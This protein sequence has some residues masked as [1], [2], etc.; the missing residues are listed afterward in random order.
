MKTVQLENGKDHADKMDMVT[1]VKTASVSTNPFDL[2]KLKLSQ[3]FGSSGGGV[4]KKL[5]MV[6]VRKPNKQTFFRVIPGDDFRIMTAILEIKD[7]GSDIYLI[8]P[9]LH[10]ELVEDMNVVQIVT[11]IDRQNNVVLW[12][13]KMPRADGRSNSWNESAMAAA[14]HAEKQWIRLVPNMSIG[15][16]DV[17]V[18]KKDFPDPEMPEVSF[19]KLIE[20]AFK[21][22]FIDS[23]GHPILRKLRG[24]E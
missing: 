15:A 16:Y 20:M 12:P 8:A 14:Q 18:A 23:M 24:E 2:G 1:Q 4:K 17:L 5:T 13:I 6:P 7:D 19:Q 10:D 3:D 11:T 22:R 9:S 21:D